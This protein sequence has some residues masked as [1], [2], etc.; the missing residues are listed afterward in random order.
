MR[1]DVFEQTV[2]D[3]ETIVIRIRAPAT[4][5][6]G[7]YVYERRASDDASVTEW[8]SARITPKLND[9]EVSIIDG[10][11]KAPHGRTKLRT[12]RDSYAR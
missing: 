1:I 8:L 7:D 5:E 9:L 12:L 2:F 11:F 3:I 10:G 6:I 4:G